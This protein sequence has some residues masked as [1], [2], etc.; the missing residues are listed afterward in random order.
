MKN[1][2]IVLVA[3]AF[4]AVS[5]ACATTRAQTPTTARPA[6]EVPPVPPRVVEP[7]L[8]PEAPAPE[9]VGELPTAPSTPA[10]PRP[11]PN[12]PPPASRETKADAKP[13]EP[14][15]TTEPAAPA[16]PPSPSP[17]GP[18]RTSRTADGPQAER[19]I[20]DTIGRANQLLGRVPFQKLSQERQA[21]YNQVKQFIE[22]AEAATKEGRFDLALEYADKA[23]NLAKQLQA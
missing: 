15:Q 16:N 19:Q 14:P 3:L 11:R 6:L 2:A 23:E 22:Q 10:P 9:L 1:L 7:V 4:G 21:V 13:T 17:V 12:T 5:A 8:P 18:L 20:R